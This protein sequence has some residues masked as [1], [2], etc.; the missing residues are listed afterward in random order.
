MLAENELGKMGWK[1]LKGQMGNRFARVAEF[2]GHEDS[3]EI[4]N[5]SSRTRKRVF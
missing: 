4:E 2:L 3:E 5:R 1:K